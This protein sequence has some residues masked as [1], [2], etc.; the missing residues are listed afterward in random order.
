LAPIADAFRVSDATTGQLATLTSLCAA[1]MALAA[2]PWMERYARRTWLRFECV[3]LGSGT[4]LSA[5]APAFAW[6][7]VGRALSGA[8]SAFIFA[9]CLAATGDLFADQRRRNWAVGLIG[10]GATL[11]AIGGLPVLTEIDARWGWRLAV[12]TLLPLAALVFVGV[13]WL[14]SPSRDPGSGARSRQGGYGIVLR[15]RP[16][17]CLLA[18][19]FGVNLVWFGWLVY[20]GA[21]AERGFDVGAHTLSLLFVTAGVAEIAANN[22]TPVLLTKRSP[23]VVIAVAVVVLAATLLEPQ[24]GI[25]RAWTLFPFIA[26]AS[27]CCVTLFTVTNILLLDALPAARGTVMSLSSAGFDIGGALGA[28]IVGAGLAAF[29]QVPVDF[30]LLAASLPLVLAFLFLGSTGLVQRRTELVVEAAVRS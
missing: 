13:A 30:A 5:L 17:L 8:G 22:A 10:T 16:T 14:P 27:F 11:G 23:R 15:D 29:G 1:A 4:I 9:T 18:A 7:V 12:G 19:M 20:F 28:S 25:G 24:W 2:A 21:Y 26:L 6:L 3:L